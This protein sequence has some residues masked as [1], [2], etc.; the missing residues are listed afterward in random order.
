MAFISSERYFQLVE[1]GAIDLHSAVS[2]YGCACSSCGASTATAAAIDGQASG[3]FRAAMQANA[4]AGEVAP[5]LAGEA[6]IS[7]LLFDTNLNDADQNIDAL[8]NVYSGT[9]S[10]Y[11]TSPNL[12]FSFPDAATDYTYTPQTGV[13]SGQLSTLQMSMVR[14]SL[15]GFAGVSNLAFTE[16]AAGSA[17]GTLRFV[18]GGTTISTAFGYYPNGQESGGDVWMNSTA[19]D[20]PVIG[21]YAFHT[22]MHEIGHALGLKHGHETNG[23]GALASSVD[24][25]EYSI[26]TYRSYVGHDLT[27]LP[28]YTN[29]S[30]SY[31]QSLMM[32]DIAAIQRFYGADFTTNGNDSIYTFSLTTGEMLINGVGQGA[33]AGNKVFRTVWD[34]AGVDT[35]DLSNYTTALNIDLTP[36]GYTNFDTSTSG[37]FQRAVLNAGFGGSTVYARGNVFNALQYQNDSRSLI[38]NAYGGS[39]SDTVTGNA[40]ANFLR[41][42]AGSD[43]LS[44]A[45]G[46]DILQGDSGADILSGG[47]GFDTASYRSANSAVQVDL[48]AQSAWDGEAADVFTSIE[49]AVGSNFSDTFV[50]D[51]GDN[52]FEGLAGNDYVNGGAGGFDMASYRSS[53]VGVQ[54]D[55]SAGYA[56]DGAAQDFLISIEGAIGSEQS[57][58]L[59]GDGLDN[60][61]EGLG[62]VD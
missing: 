44:G 9:N 6:P 49:G 1:Q 38:E 24:S 35:Y 3:D 41:G 25:M 58:I 51:A 62:G 2:G 5:P 32:Y 60:I 7:L 42:N 26:M 23:P 8:M 36:G 43:A 57:D 28:Y 12:T 55:L 14:T 22:F 37:N 40:A 30:T 21:N 31:A 34:G 48:A 45:A 16:M 54:V 17:D 10:S 52:T 13:F 39:A 18:E 47:V 46:D 61:F 20:A 33:P 56:W 11:W 59:I 53:A 15:A 27:T 50:G 29:G 19:Y 4:L